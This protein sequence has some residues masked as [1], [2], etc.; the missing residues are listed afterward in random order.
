MKW[1]AAALTQ[2]VETT[3][4][5]SK[6]NSSVLISG[7]NSALRMELLFKSSQR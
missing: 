6:V 1:R 4:T 3:V 5:E 2:P 7:R